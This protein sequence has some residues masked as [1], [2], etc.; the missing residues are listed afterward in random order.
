MSSVAGPLIFCSYATPDRD[1]V[2]KYADY[3]EDR[4]FN[5]WIDFKQ[6]VAGQNFGW[7]ISRALDKSIGL[8]EYPKN[9]N[10][11]ELLF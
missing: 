9:G 8:T 5:I 2:V 3:L 11:L 1:E 10:I 6:L 4:G 7:E